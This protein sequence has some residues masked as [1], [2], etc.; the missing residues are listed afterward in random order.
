MRA[1]PHLTMFVAEVGCKSLE[2]Q[3][4]NTDIDGYRRDTIV[5]DKV[6]KA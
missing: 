3:E 1:A 5:L 2:T 6:P 4:I